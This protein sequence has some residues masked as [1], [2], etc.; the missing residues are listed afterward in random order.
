M[1]RWLAFRHSLDWNLVLRGASYGG[2][3]QCVHLAVNKGASW[4]NYGLYE[5]YLGGQLEVA[6]FMISKGA[7]DWNRGLRAACEGGHHIGM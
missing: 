1:M 2:H 4:W 6:E 3:L 5:A 7:D